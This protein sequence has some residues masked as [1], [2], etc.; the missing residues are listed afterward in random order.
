V[1]PSNETLRRLAKFSPVVT[2]AISLGVMAFVVNFAPAGLDVQDAPIR[3][4]LL[5]NAALA[6]AGSGWGAVTHERAPEAQIG[7]GALGFVA[8]V[9]LCFA[10]MWLPFIRGGFG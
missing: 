10:G 5:I 2:A 1:D 8:Y 6:A 3:N 7:F 4:L 9:A